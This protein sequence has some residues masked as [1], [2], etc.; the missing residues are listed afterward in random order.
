MPRLTELIARAALA[1][2]HIAGDE[3][4]LI[5]DIT[6]DSREVKPGTLF[7]ALSGTRADGA[8]YIPDAIRRG[9]AAV[10][11]ADA[12]RMDM[13][14]SVPVVRVGD[15]RA[16]ISALASAMY[17]SQPYCLF[18]VTGTDGKTSTADFTRQLAVLNGHKAASI[19]TLGLRS[20]VDAI[21][22]KFPAL[23]TS[24]E[25]VLLHRTLSALADAG[26]THAAIEASSHGLDQKRL[27][28]LKLTA[29]AFTNLARDHLDYH[30]TVEAYARAKQRL[31]DTL[32]PQ[33][34]TAVLNRDDAQFVPLEKI[35]RSR[36]I[37]VTS[38]GHDKKADYH[39]AQVTPHADGLSATVVINGKNHA[40]QLPFYGAFQLSNM[41]AASGMLAARGIAI[42]TILA[43][44]PQLTGVPGRLEKVASKDGA[45]IF[46]DYAHTPAAL[47]NILKTLRA[48]TSGRLIV[49]FGCGG[50]RDQGKRPEMGAAANQYADI[51]IVTDDNPRSEDPA[52]IRA[53]ILAAAPR[54]QEIPDRAAAIRGAVQQAKPGDVL[55]VAGKGHETTQTIGT[56]VI[57]FSDQETI[58]E[59]LA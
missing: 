52:A 36:G 45:P 46:V 3:S 20:P 31:F 49:V 26:V 19:G 24:P 33:G 50:D 29:A 27:D 9:A 15:V 1:G 48:H 8:Q 28:G 6:S 17:P 54:A 38:F 58:R 7:V 12:A 13:A 16:A 32:L 47:T 5:T 39:I 4:A 18:A 51:A 14:A 22:A 53:A 42:E 37:A 56:Q 2:A 10:L 34:K 41:L 25:P 21:N 35:C 43:Q 30:G 57:H 55:V 23:N 40:L 11:L 59:A 44:L